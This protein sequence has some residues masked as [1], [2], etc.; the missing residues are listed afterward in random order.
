M[1]FFTFI[2]ILLKSQIFQIRFHSY[3]NT[4]QYFSYTSLKFLLYFLKTF[5]FSEIFH[6]FLPNSSE[7][8]FR[9][10]PHFSLTF[11]G[12]SFRFSKNFRQINNPRPFLFSNFLKI[13]FEYVS[14]I[15]AIFLKFLSYFPQNYFTSSI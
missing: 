1:M 4:L 8:S 3:S 11:L 2:E 12:F 6:K 9:F 15:S 7:I 10:S 5:D 14:D 13:S